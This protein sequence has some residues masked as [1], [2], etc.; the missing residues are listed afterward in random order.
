MTETPTTLR[1]E[2]AAAAAEPAAAPS[3]PTPDRPRARRQSPTTTFLRTVV[4][5][6]VAIVA[7]SIYSNSENDAFLTTDNFQNI[8]S[9]VSVLGILAAGQTFLVI[10]GQLDLSVGSLV[11]FVAVV[12]AKLF[13][14][15]WSTPAVIVLCLA[16][17]AAT[18]LVWGLV[19]AFLR[20]PPFILT[21]G[22]LSVFAS[23]ALVLADN[24]PVAVLEGLGS[25]GFGEWLGIRAPVIV[26]LVTMIVLGLV[27]HFTR[28]GRNTYALGSSQ[29][30]AYLAGVPTRRLTVQLF[31]LNSTL[32]SLGGLVMMSRLAAGDP[33]SGVG[34]ELTT[35]AVTVL[36]GAALAGGRGTMVGAFLG[37]V[38]FGVIS[39]SLTFLQVPGAYQSLVSGGILIFAVIATAVADLRSG[40]VRTGGRAEAF[41]AAITGLVTRRPSPPPA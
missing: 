14:A 27:L 20:V 25:L 10:G 32:A 3:N 24:R 22:G 40:R 30:A 2:P 19:V 31:V 37:T 34:L 26:V 8:L 6:L 13:G 4:P 12:A 16:I 39:A 5:L 36:G 38:L 23:L 9:Q 21:L 29:Q 11:S 15:G 7:L 17:G 28:F 33:R 1:K 18:G 35:I 41:G